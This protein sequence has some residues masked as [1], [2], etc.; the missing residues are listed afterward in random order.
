LI[1]QVEELVAQQN[2]DSQ[3]LSAEAERELKER[4]SNLLKERNKLL[5]DMSASDRQITDIDV[6]ANNPITGKP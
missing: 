4:R 1:V 3:G 6:R 5:S 2:D